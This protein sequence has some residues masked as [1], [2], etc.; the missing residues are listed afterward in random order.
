MKQTKFCVGLDAK[1]LE[2]SINDALKEINAQETNILYF[3]DKMTAII[4]YEENQRKSM[5]VDCSHYDP[6]GDPCHKAWGLCHW[7]GE[8]VRFNAEKCRDFLDKR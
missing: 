2:Q 7:N 4:E 3:L 1:R 8:R 6:N 5:C